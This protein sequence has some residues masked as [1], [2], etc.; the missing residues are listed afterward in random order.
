[1]RKA[2]ATPGAH[3][4]R[5]RGAAVTARPRPPLPAAPTPGPAEPQPAATAISAL[6]FT[7][8][9][10]GLSASSYSPLPEGRKE[11]T[12]SAVRALH[13]EAVP[14]ARGEPCGEGKLC[15]EEKRPRNPARTPHGYPERSTAALN[16]RRHAEPPKRRAGLSRATRCGGNRGLP[17]SFS[18]LLLSPSLRVY[19]MRCPGGGWEAGGGCSVSTE[20]GT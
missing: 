6:L 20:A 18:S 19:F 3:L 12:T 1:M 9:L 8:V 2:A 13:L 15:G 7:F 17:R 10:R 11:R 14:A 4:R 5:E 16:R